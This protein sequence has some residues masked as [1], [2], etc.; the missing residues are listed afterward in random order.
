MIVLILTVFI[1]IKHTPIN[2]PELLSLWIDVYAGY[3]A[4]TLNYATSITAMLATNRVDVPR[5][6]LIKNCIIENNK[7]LFA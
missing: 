6:L 7:A 2:R 5:I 1:W 4:D 3:D